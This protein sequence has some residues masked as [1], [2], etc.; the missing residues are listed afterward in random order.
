VDRIGYYGKSK[1]PANYGYVFKLR[2][3]EV[4]RT[5]YDVRSKSHAT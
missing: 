1:P 2:I 5:G 4:N 3:S